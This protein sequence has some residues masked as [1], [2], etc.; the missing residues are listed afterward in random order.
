MTVTIEQAQA[1]LADLIAKLAPGQ[2]FI[3]TENEQQIARVVA[4]TAAPHMIPPRVPGTAV[5]Q[6]VILQDDDEHLK[7]FA[8]YMP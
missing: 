5:G 2:E 3:I 8:E 6:L 7:D 1:H 4:G